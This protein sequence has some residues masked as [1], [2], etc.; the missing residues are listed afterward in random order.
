M[1]YTSY[2]FRA[3]AL[4]EGLELEVVYDLL[5]AELAEVGFD[6]F[7][8]GAETLLAYIPT[9]LIDQEAIATAIH[10]TLDQLSS[11]GLR[12]SYHIET[13]PEVNWN[14]EWERNYFQPII[15]GNG[16]CMIRAPFHTPEPSI[17]TE[18]IISPKM[19]FGTGNHETTALVIEYLLSLGEGLQGKRV[20]DMGC[21]TGILGIL[22]LKQGA[23]HL[24]AIDID[25]WAYH[26]VL[27][28][29]SLNGVSIPDALQG[30][31]SSL[32]GRE[33]YDLVLANITRNILLQDLPAYVEVMRP[34][35]TIALS[36]F[37][38][39]DAPLLIERGR[40][41]GLTL[42]DQRSNNRWTLLVLQR[43]HTD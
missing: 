22:A 11:D 15:L 17:K 28:N 6:S 30:D 14:E 19:A 36:G 1:Q 4:P 32:S 34:L 27:E 13:I 25:E 29:A 16:L 5:S 24:T 12:L 35:G 37:Y 26:N 8:A 3:E 18:V 39:E 20:L 2:T 43:A 31:A 10:A 23:G 38:Q 7:E 42:I 9:E 41:L 21:G 33:P 40:Q